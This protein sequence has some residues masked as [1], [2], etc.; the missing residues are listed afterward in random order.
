MYPSTF[1]NLTA[2]REQLEEI[3][4]KGQGLS[5]ETAQLLEFHLQDHENYHSISD[6]HGNDLLT[7]PDYNYSV[8]GSIYLYSKFY[9][10]FRILFIIIIIIYFN[11]I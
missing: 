11:I 7:L 2:V 5:E 9:Y 4:D 3:R 6:S 8:Y 1:S 10:R